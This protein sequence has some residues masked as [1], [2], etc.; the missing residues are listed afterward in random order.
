MDPLAEKINVLYKYRIREIYFIRGK[1][2]LQLNW[3]NVKSLVIHKDYDGYIRPQYI[4][5][6]QLDNKTNIWI[7]RHQNDFQVFLDI[8]K[9]LTDDMGDQVGPTVQFMKGLFIAV[10]PT[11]SS[12]SIDRIQN[13]DGTI[14]NTEDTNDLAEMMVGNPVTIGLIQRDMYNKSMTAANAIAKK[15]NLQDLVLSM[16]TKAGF[17]KVLMCPFQ[18]YKI[19][20]DII[21]PPLPLF[22]AIQ[23]LDLKYGFYKA[24]A[25]IFYDYDTVYFIDTSMK[26]L[27]WRNGDSPYCTLNIFESTKNIINGH[28][29]GTSARELFVANSS[30]N[31]VFGEEIHTAI[32]ST[33]TVV[34]VNSGDKSPV[35]YASANMNYLESSAVVY[36]SDQVAEYVAQRQMEDKVRLDIAG[37]HYDIDAFNP[38]ILTSIYHSNSDI[39][40]KIAGKYR[41]S[42]VLSEIYNQGDNFVSNTT[43]SY[44]YCGK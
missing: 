5:T 39:Q 10:N 24:G 8:Q 1:E 20:E 17:K 18:N 42:T 29:T 15:T 16:L 36:G 7:S 2:V 32:G 14:L 22:K 4:L 26:H 3:T 40:A 33:T 19:Y 44:V 28:V 27:V 38:N 25:V 13:A 9:V 34:D 31:I 23:Y 11:T 6:L 41:V 35:T 12:I 37:Y 21:V 30:T 43:V